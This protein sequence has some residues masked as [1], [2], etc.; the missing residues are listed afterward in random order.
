MKM[1]LKTLM[2]GF[3]AST[4][5]FSCEKNN[6]KTAETLSARDSAFIMEAAVLNTAEIQAG[7]LADSTSDTSTIKN[8]AMS[9]VS[10]HQAAQNDLKSLGAKV[11]ITVADSTNSYNMMR[12]D[13]LRNLSG[14]AFDS[15]F[16]LN[17][18]TD[19]TKA[20]S[21]YQAE[22]TSGNHTSVVNYA[23][24]YLPTLQKHL[25]TADSIASAMHFQ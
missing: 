25:N 6:G 13:S 2:L 19:H 3:I 20:I 1:T 5:F 9:L 11:N 22:A 10:D 4:I 14:R 24:Q 18:I 7:Q 12:L 15:A 17:Q 21:D 16:I 23:N 8:F